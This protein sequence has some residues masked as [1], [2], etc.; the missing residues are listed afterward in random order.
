M[1]NAVPISE[2]DMGSY[3]LITYALPGTNVV[4]SLDSWLCVDKKT[5]KPIEKGFYEILKDL[6]DAKQISPPSQ[7]TD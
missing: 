5:K 4:T 3:I 6:K 2:W 7:K 1:K